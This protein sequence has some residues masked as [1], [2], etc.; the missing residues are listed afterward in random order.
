MEMFIKTQKNSFIKRT[1][2]DLLRYKGVLVKWR[3]NEGVFFDVRRASEHAF[4][5]RNGE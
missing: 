2:R 1:S 5:V 3:F 4:K